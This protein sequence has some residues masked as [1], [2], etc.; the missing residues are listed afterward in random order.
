MNKTAVG[1]KYP[2]PTLRV[3]TK[4]N[5]LSQYE[6]VSDNVLL[7]KETGDIVNGPFDIGHIQDGSI[8]D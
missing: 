2:R 4:K 1:D 8:E 7:H 5:I 3:E 6:Q